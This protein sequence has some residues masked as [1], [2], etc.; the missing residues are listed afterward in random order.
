MNMNKILQL[1]FAGIMLVLSA[2]KSSPSYDGTYEGIVPAAD[3]PGIY[4]LL[5]I[6]GN[7]YELLEKYIMHSETF[8]TYGET[9][10]SQENNTLC[11]DNEMELKLSENSLFY[12]GMP[13]KR[14]SA[15]KKLPEIY[16]TQFL[17]E[18]KTGEDANVKFYSLKDQRYAD[19]HFK[20]KE[21]KLKL[22]PEN[23]AI[24]EY[25]DANN[26]LSISF[27]KQT[28]PS[29]GKISF[30]DGTNVYTFA[31]LS[32]T[33]CIYNINKDENT[34]STIPSAFDVTYYNDGKQNFAKLIDANCEHYYTL[35]QTEASAKTATY[36]DRKTTWMLGNQKNGILIIGNKKHQYKEQ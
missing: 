19:F 18:Y 33:S 5:T 25:S 12:Q 23:N 2:C 26:S 28:L 13:L 14:I 10:K 22:N 35:P 21:Y 31:Q 27:E 7:K 8:I 29:T 3:C 9:L 16:T 6:D 24:D 32:P 34:D 11:M 4:I 36:T 30:N 17:K 1:G 20:G 15:Q